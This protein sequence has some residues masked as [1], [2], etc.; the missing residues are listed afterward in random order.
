MTRLLYKV[1]VNDS[2]SQE[3]Q[4]GNTRNTG[5]DLLRI[6]SM[7]MVVLLHVNIHG[8]VLN[9]VTENT[10][11]WYMSRFI[12][13]FCIVAV[14]I[15]AM[16]SGYV[17]YGKKFKITNIFSLWLQVLIYSLGIYLLSVA[18]KDDVTFENEIFREYALPVSTKRY[19]Y[20]SAYFFVFFTFP[21][22][23]LIIEKSNKVNAT[24]FI[25]LILFLIT[26]I[27]DAK[28]AFTMGDGYSTIWLIV[29]Y[30]VGAYFKKYDF[31]LKF[32]DYKINKIIYLI[33]YVFFTVFGLFI[34][35]LGISD[36]ALGRVIYY[37][38]LFNVLSAISLFLFYSKLKIKQSKLLTL[39][40]TASFGV[41]IIS[42]HKY[43]AQEFMTDKFKQ[44]ITCN[45]FYMALVMVGKS[46]L[47]FVCCIIVDIIRIYLFKFV[48]FNKLMKKLQVK[49]DDFYKNYMADS[50]I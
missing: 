21:A 38:Y 22:L 41:Y 35:K 8:G 34:Y 1:T 32:K 15:F 30:L 20:F 7:F 16:I 3:R 12:E 36:F 42:S 26:V 29:L 6:L 31:N 49:I 17:N 39:L 46:L 47:M 11:Q 27:G 37:T 45:P 4:A 33:M 9:N 5:L 18:I 24:V 44:Y 50:D 14:N 19:W 2:V 43:F 10:G 40:S 23:N 28:N 48:G 13:Q 25:V